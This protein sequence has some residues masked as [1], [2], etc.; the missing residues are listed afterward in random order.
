[1]SFLSL[2]LLMA[3]GFVAGILVCFELG[4]RIGRSALAAS[5]DG[6]AKGVG[7]AEGAVFA[8]V[9]AVSNPYNWD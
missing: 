1:M 7:P 2:N 5:P 3:A 6:L 9:D 4:R 8:P